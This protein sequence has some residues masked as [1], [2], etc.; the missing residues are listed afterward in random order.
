M[1]L[2][3]RGSFSM[4]DLLDVARRLELPVEEVETSLR[5]RT[6]RQRV[7]DDVSEGR[8]AGVH[9]T[10]TFFLDGRLMR[11]PWRRLAT[12]VPTLLAE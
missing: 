4:P 3:G 8:N 2:T 10:P 9:A 5:E 12:R 11:G 1:L 7:V 6:H